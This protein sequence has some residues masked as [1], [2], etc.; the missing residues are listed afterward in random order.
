VVFFTERDRVGFLLATV[1]SVFAAPGAAPAYSL[2]W[3]TVSWPG[4]SGTLTNTY[5]NVDASGW[6]VQV[7]ITDPDSNLVQVADGNPA[8]PSTNTHLDPPSNSGDN[9]FVRADAN[10]GGAGITIR[11]DFTHSTL[12][13]VTD[14]VLSLIDVD[15]CDAPCTQWIDY[16]SI[17]G[18]DSGG[19]A[20]LPDSVVSPTGTPTWTYDALTGVLLGGPG[21]G[22]RRKR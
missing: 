5:V 17:T 3:D 13:D 15:A 22:K 2:D 18:Y 20:I 9:L 12:T 16:I 6:S 1:L 11:I 10:G 4:G 19:S 7:Q 8:S 14:I 21:R